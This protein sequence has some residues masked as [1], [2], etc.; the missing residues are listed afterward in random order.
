MIRIPQTPY[1]LHLKSN[2]TIDANNDLFF[3]YFHVNSNVRSA[4]ESG[5]YVKNN[6]L[7]H[8]S[9]PL[10]CDVSLLSTEVVK[11]TD[12][13]CL[14]IFPLLT[15]SSCV[16]MNPD[17]YSFGNYNICKWLT[18]DTYCIPDHHHET[19]ITLLIVFKKIAPVG[20]KMILTRIIFTFI[21]NNK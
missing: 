9:R 6:I 1:K 11:M 4:N 15:K 18:N 2:I 8:N 5:F 14:S 21:E 12:G 19:V 10:L 13:T 20:I 7:Y 16:I 3:G 17:N